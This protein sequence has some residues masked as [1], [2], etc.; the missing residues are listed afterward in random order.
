MVSFVLQFLDSSLI[1]TTNSHL[2]TPMYY[3]PSLLL[4]HHLRVQPP[5]GCF[6]PST[7]CGA[8]AFHNWEREENAQSGGRRK[9]FVQLYKK[10]FWR[11]IY[12]ANTRPETDIQSGSMSCRGLVRQSPWIMHDYNRANVIVI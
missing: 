12:C 10:L 5:G 3:V 4:P 2:F 9:S 8:H 7:A 6:R 1:F 11:A